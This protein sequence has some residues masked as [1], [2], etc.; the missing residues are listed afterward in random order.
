MTAA[1]SPQTLPPLATLSTRLRRDLRSD[2]AGETGAVYIYRAILKF[3]HDPEIIAFATEH[4]ATEERHLSA[5]ESWLPKH[6]KSRLIFLWRVA[7][8]SLGAVS[9][10]GGRAG[11]YRTIEAVERF[12]VIHYQEQL[13]Y[14]EGNGDLSSITDLLQSFLDDEDSHRADAEHRVGGNPGVLS[15]VWSAIVGGGSSAAVKV[16]R[17]I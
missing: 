5:F 13:D 9:L 10:L 17:V 1:F 7:G 12:V 6:E 3:T 4:L 2:H 14:L 15:R 8:W 11:V 16:C